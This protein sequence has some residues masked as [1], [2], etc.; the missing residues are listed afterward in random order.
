MVTKN[1]KAQK[2]AIPVEFTERMANLLLVCVEGLRSQIPDDDRLNIEL[3][4]LGQ[5]INKVASNKKTDLTWE[6]E[7]YFKGRTLA[8]QF[9]EA[10]KQAT[11]GIA[12]GMA[13]ALKEVIGDVGSYD[14]TLDEC[15]KDIVAANNLKDISAIKKKIAFAVKK[16]KSKTQTIK[17]ELK[18]NQNALFS[19][20][21]KLKQSQPKEVIDSLTKIL[22]RSAYEMKIVQVIHDFQRTGD[23]VCLLQCDLDH[24]K[25]F[26]ETHGQRAGDKILSSIA[27]TIKSSIRDSDD[28]FRIGG[29]EFV[30]LLYGAPVENA[31]KVAEKIR[32]E[33]KR[34]FLV[35]KKKELKVSIS[36]GVAFLQE[37][38]TE[39][40][41]FERADKAL[42]EAKQKGRDCVEISPVGI[43]I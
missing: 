37:G 18:I 23:S 34:D 27:S 10:E 30:V 29:E 35:Y 2:R 6:I 28:I 40:S 26:N 5:V 17:K 20:S 13:F 24:F 32:S 42:H 4:K 3:D 16:S 19:L 22:N 38:D 33:V 36:L 39:T 41:V 31:I 9:Q 21:K 15:N 8:K 25:K 1:P 43:P 14:Q 11:K 12:L 7:G